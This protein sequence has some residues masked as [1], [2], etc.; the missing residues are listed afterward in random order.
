MGLSCGQSHAELL[1]QL[2]LVD[3]KHSDRQQGPG[4][5]PLYTI[6]LLQLSSRKATV[7]LRESRIRISNALV[8]VPA[9]S[10]S[11]FPEGGTPMQQQLS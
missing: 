11:S 5:H 6:H 4:S 2:G 8:C 9:L 10:P 3:L 7:L 1:Q